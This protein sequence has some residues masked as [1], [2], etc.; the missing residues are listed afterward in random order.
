MG[1]PELLVVAGK[2]VGDG[3]LL[4]A[5]RRAHQYCRLVLV[6]SVKSRRQAQTEPMTASNHQPLNLPIEAK[7]RVSREACGFDHRM[8]LLRIR[9]GF[10]AETFA[11]AVQ[12]LVQG[13]K[14]AHGEYAAA[15]AIEFALRALDIRRERILPPQAPPETV[16]ALA[17]RWTYAVMVASLLKDLRDGDQERAC[18]LFEASVQQE[19]RHWLEQDGQVWDAL[20]RFLVGPAA[21]TNPISQIIEAASGPVNG[22]QQVM[23]PKPAASFPEGLAGDFMRWVGAGLASRSL[24]VN[25]PQAL[26][27]RV[28]EGLLL[29]SPAIFRVFLL[30]SREDSDLSHEGLEKAG[31]PLRHLQREV[32]KLRWHLRGEDGHD[33]LAYTW[34]SGPKAGVKVHGLVI[35]PAQ[36]LVDSL[37]TLNEAL[38]RFAPA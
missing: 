23:E 28:P 12:P 16:G 9:M 22:P 5:C 36:R 3:A 17:P 25:T 4:A 18:D 38:E 26:V 31:D 27:H 24:V 20:V 33:L 35:T 11:L 2:A 13:L 30:S 34:K 29:L 15:R 21:V 37:P 19:A 10:P 14:D 7:K 8:A 6:Q 1:V 32:N